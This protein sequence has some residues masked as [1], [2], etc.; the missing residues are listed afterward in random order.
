MKSCGVRIAE[1]GVGLAL[2]ATPMA[3]AE[4]SEA[5]VN[6]VIEVESGGR[7]VSGDNGKAVGIGQVHEAACADVGIAH[8]AAWLPS[9]G[10][11]ATRRYLTQ[12]QAR[13]RCGMR[14]EPTAAQLYAAYNV[15]P[16]RFAQRGYNI[17]RC[18]RI[19]RERAA[20]VQRC[21]N[22]ATH[23]ALSARTAAMFH[24][25]IFGGQASEPPA[26]LDY[27]PAQVAMT[28]T[29]VRSAVPHNQPQIGDP[30]KK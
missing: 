9:T 10:R 11:E 24:K 5:M 15:G 8:E 20:R 17:A 13:L 26:R 6:A 12:L 29:A 14:R 16:T 21:V 3:A 28:L 18:P 23:A 7:N 2:V 4:I 25:P 22:D 30:S 1:C 19:T 27:C